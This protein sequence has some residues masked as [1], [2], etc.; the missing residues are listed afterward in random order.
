ML[1]KVVS[2]RWVITFQCVCNRALV[3]TWADNPGAV[4]SNPSFANIL[5]DVWQKSLWPASF[6][7]HQWANRC[8][9]AASCL[10]SMLCGSLVEKAW[11]Q[12]NR[13]TGHHNMTEKLL[14]TPINQ[15]INKCVCIWEMVIWNS[16]MHEYPLIPWP[17][18]FGF[19]RRTKCLIIYQ[20]F[21]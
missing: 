13:W 9:K 17:K 2:S 19:Y 16:I 7:F 3:A 5:S 1:T 20:L 8:G 14:K 15:S 10:E 6:V 18:L 21:L 12:I 4:S 11:K